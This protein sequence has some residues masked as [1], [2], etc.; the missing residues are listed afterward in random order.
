MTDMT[1]L[2]GRE[3]MLFD[4]EF[5]ATIHRPGSSE[6]LEWLHS[7]TFFY[8]P[9]STMYHEAKQGG[10]VRHSIRVYYNLYNLCK[11]FHLN[12]SEIS[13]DYLEK[14]AICG[15]LH[16]I[17]KIGCY[18]PD[19]RNVKKYDFTM[20][21][22]DET[23]AKIKTDNNGDFIWISKPTYKF[24]DEFP[25]GHGEKSV[26]LIQKFMQLTD[27]EAVAIRWHMGTFTDE[28][29]NISNAYNKYPFALLLSMA[30][31]YTTFFDE[32]YL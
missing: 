28:T 22:L 27:E 19:F 6:L 5:C 16:D 3:T 15:L 9:A 7:T 21:D 11:E 1:E 8:D 23:G 31:Q 2:N 24:D 4:A 17:C 29:R 10:L 30:D 25:L 13:S 12:T 32:K 18:K 14:I 20:K 26:Y